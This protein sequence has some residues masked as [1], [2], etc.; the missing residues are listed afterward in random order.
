MARVR[1]GGALMATANLVFAHM[2]PAPR[3]IAATA[4]VSVVVAYL[5]LVQQEA[6]ATTP[7]VPACTAPWP[8]QISQVFLYWLAA[9]WRAVSRLFF[10]AAPG[11]TNPSLSSPWVPP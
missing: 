11:R 5:A 3:G 1:P 7:S 6:A 8:L 2:A 9:V 4:S 10:A